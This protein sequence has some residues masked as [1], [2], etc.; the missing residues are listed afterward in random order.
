MAVERE[1]ERERKRER[2]KERKREREKGRKGEREEE[3]KR[4]RE[5]ERERVVG[6]TVS[7]F[8]KSSNFCRAERTSVY[9]DTCMCASM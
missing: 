8:L 2:E 6:L 9:I 1:K 4:G 3:R 5:E 7:S